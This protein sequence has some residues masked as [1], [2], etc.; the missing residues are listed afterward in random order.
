MPSP[1]Q[2][3]EQLTNIANDALM[4][5]VLWH[6]AIGAGL[7]AVAIGWR[8]SQRLTG[9]L[10]ALPIGSVAVLAWIYSN[11]FTGT[12]FAVAAVVLALLSVRLG[13]EPIQTPGATWMVAGSAMLAF[14]WVYPHFLEDSPASLYLVGA[15]LGTIP[16]PTLAAVI[17]LAL[18]GSG[19]GSRAWSLILAAVGVFYGVFGAFR[20]GVT[21]DLVMLAGALILA[22]LVVWPRVAVELW[23]ARRSPKGLGGKSAAGGTI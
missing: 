16:C 18:L 15:P 7:A 10:L 19:L 2:I 3:V 13:K 8:P 5:A 17:G 4:V 6:V 14:G 11:P 12:V 22:V 9:F 20:L 23:R 1:E 21:M